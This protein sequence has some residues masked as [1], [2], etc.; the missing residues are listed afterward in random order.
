VNILFL[1]HRIPYP[2]DKGDKIRS[3]NEVKHL[4]KKHKIY[5]GTLC[6][7]ENE[8]FYASKLAP[9]CEKIHLGNAGNKLKMLKSG[10]NGRP[11]SVSYF[12][13]KSLQNFVDEVLKEIHIHAII[14]FCSSM[15]EYILKNPLFQRNSLTDTKL[16][17]DFVDLDSDKWLQYSRYSRFPFNFVYRV[18]NKRLF[19]YEI[20]INKAFDHS[21]FVSQREVNVLNRLCSDCKNVHVIQN[22]VNYKYFYPGTSNSS[23]KKKKPILVFTGVMDYFANIDGVRW[24]CNKI[25]PRIKQEFPFAQFYIVGNNPTN[26]VW[27]LSELD[28]V[29]VTGYV[30]DIR[31]YY[32][33]ADVC[34]IPLRIARGLQ[35]KVLE[36][37]ASG[38]AVVATSNAADGIIYHENRDIIISDNEEMFAKE[39]IKL[40]TDK[41]TSQKMGQNALANIRQNYSWED[42]LAGFDKLLNNSKLEK[43]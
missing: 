16:I 37:M 13:D 15:A 33:M 14:C 9:L 12:Y 31:K 8:E 17:I 34:V 41:H 2:P 20:M 3:Y 6:H 36:A 40:I 38:K 28:G 7:S 11:F 26:F 29:T 39:V 4:S 42:N 30:K 27:S 43:I 19:K 5:L 18:E 21:V 22:G 1:A 32:R 24:F 25:F 23:N 35:N 10:I